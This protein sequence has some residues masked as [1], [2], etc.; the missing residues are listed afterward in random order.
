MTDLL[1]GFQA[2][3]TATRPGDLHGR[4]TGQINLTCIE[5][6]AGSHVDQTPLRGRAHVAIARLAGV[7]DG[8]HGHIILTLAGHL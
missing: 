6:R 2:H 5:D 8:E 4:A 7:S 1:V 3:C